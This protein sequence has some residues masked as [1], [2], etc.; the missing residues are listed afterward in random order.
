[1]AG[2]GVVLLLFMIGLELSFA[3]LWVMRRLVLALGGAD[4]RARAA[5][6]GR[7]GGAAAAAGSDQAGGDP[8]R[9]NFGSVTSGVTASKTTRS[10]APSRAPELSPTRLLTSSGPSASCTRQTG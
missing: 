4:I 5:G 3:R 10:G 6:A 1:M 2:F 9:L 8:S 7:A